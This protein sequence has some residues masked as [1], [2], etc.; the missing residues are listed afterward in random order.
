MNKI[1]GKYQFNKRHRYKLN[2]ME[3]HSGIYKDY[4][5]EICMN[6]GFKREFQIK[7]SK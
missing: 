3:K 2:S 5:G 1:C 7:N 4:I 6:C